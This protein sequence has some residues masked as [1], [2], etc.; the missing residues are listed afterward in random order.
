MTTAYVC[1]KGVR[2]IDIMNSDK[3]N[4][5]TICCMPYV[6][7]HSLRYIITVYKSVEEKKA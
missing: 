5:C 2:N 7:L 6:W 3:A 4:L 1:V